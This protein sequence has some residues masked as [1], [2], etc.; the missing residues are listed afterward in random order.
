MRFIIRADI[1]FPGHCQSLLLDNGTVAYTNGLTLEQYA[2]E[3]GF[4]VRVV[5]NDELEQLERAHI[6]SLVTEPCEESKEHFWDALECLPPSKWRTV[7]GVEMFHICERITGDLVAWHCHVGER[8][9][10][11]NDRA[12]KPADE[13]AAKA[14]A[15]FAA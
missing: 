10:T 4:P 8:Y 13:I 1:P 6:D 7:R 14:A 3:R 12:G 2:Q 9:A 11:F 5:E 15:F